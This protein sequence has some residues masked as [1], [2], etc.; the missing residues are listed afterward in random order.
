MVAVAYAGRR[1]LVLELVPPTAPLAPRP[2]RRATPAVYRRRRLAAGAG[3]MAV[4]GLLATA[5]AVV[6]PEATPV[7]EAA[8][9]SGAAVA[10][11]GAV[12]PPLAAA[13]APATAAAV[14]VVGAGDTLW[15][16]ARRVQPEGDVRPLVQ[17]WSA[18][19]GGRPLQAGE[20]VALSS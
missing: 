3:V 15:S 6:V 14:V 20:R 17:R 7:P 16:L 9:I 1:E 8:A 11:E 18:A 5:A 13:A 4:A 2:V 10:P 19:R 12:A